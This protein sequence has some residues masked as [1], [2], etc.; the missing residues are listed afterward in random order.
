MPSPNPRLFLH[1]CPYTNND[2]PDSL[3]G[4]FPAPVLRMCGT[5]D[6]YSRRFNR[7]AICEKSSA[8]P[9]PQNV[10]GASGSP[11]CQR[12][13]GDHAGP[14]RVHCSARAVVSE[15]C[16]EDTVHGVVDL[17]I[18]DERAADA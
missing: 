1:A 18:H 5:I 10:P 14:V 16:L 17:S 9:E 8:L 4:A 3:V 2:Q 12:R 6:A 7:P 13:A 11:T 15:E